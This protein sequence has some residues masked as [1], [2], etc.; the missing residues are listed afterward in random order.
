MGVNSIQTARSALESLQIAVQVTAN[1]IATSDNIGGKTEDVKFISFVTGSSSGSYTSG[2]TQAK[3]IRNVD[4][5][6][7]LKSANSTTDLAFKDPNGF[8]VVA[9]TPAGAG[10]RYTRAGDFQ[11]DDRGFLKN[12][13]G[14]YLMGWDVDEGGD[15]A[16]DVN[17]SI[18]DDLKVINVNRVDGKN[19]PT[20]QVDFRSNLPAF[21]VDD[22]GNPISV[23]MENNTIITV[24][25]SLGTSHNVK[26]FFKSVS[27]TPRQWNMWFESVEADAITQGEGGLDWGDEPG[28][29]IEFDDQGLIA[30]FNGDPT[31]PDLF[32]DWTDT[33][34]NA[35]SSTIKLNLGAVGATGGLT[36]KDGQFSPQVTRNDGRQY[37][38]ISGTFI[39]PNGVISVVFKNSESLKISRIAV[40]NF[41][42]PNELEPQDG[43]TFTQTNLSGSFVLG[44]ANT[45]GA[46]SILSGSL[47][48]S[49]V[50]LSEQLTKLIEIQHSFAANTRTITT[51]DKML[52]ELLQTVR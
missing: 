10:I 32:I 33:N 34:T 42:A 4:K 38:S 16:P 13:A 31:P 1:N 43:Q 2:T 26:M 30:N 28:I 18:L 45:A 11:P 39:D 46:S 6:G 50:E 37:S 27:T 36:C 41:S 9:E 48:F 49:Q 35:Q 22:A 7:P 5:Q 44:Y 8:F 23:G 15:V 25:D 24:Y 47:E 12:A 21:G 29:T 40:A 19:Q 3:V 51:A 17:I 14:Y 20:T 52:S